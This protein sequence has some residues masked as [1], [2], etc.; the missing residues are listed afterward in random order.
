MIRNTEI[1]A[2][3]KQKFLGVTLDNKLNFKDHINNISSKVKSA[4][5]ILWKLSQF[6]PSEVLTKIYYSLVYPYLIYGVEIWGNSSRVALDRLG[7]LV[8]TAQKRTKTNEA[9][10]VLASKHH[11]S[12]PQ[13]HKLFSLVRFYKYYR[14]KSN[15]YFFEK[16]SS[17]LPNH[18]I[19]TRFNANN[20]LN[21]P[22]ITVE[23]MKSSFFY[24]AYNYWKHLPGPIRETGNI[25]SFKRIVR[26]HIEMNPN[27]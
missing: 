21:T 16:F 13:I 18:N 7:R 27:S 8:Q 15:D 26:Q 10:P 23:K 11:L 19:N 2:C 14:L 3:H 5:G 9:I 25:Y 24:S 22:R 6:C 4:N 20:Q 17:L 1:M 12:V